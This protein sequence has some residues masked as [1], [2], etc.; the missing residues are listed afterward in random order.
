MKEK[1]QVLCIL[2]EHNTRITTKSCCNDYD[3]KSVNKTKCNCCNIGWTKECFLC[4]C[5]VIPLLCDKVKVLFLSCHKYLPQLCLKAN[6]KNIPVASSHT[7]KIKT[8]CQMKSK[9]SIS[10]YQFY[11]LLWEKK[12]HW[13][14]NSFPA[15]ILVTLAERTEGSA[16]RWSFVGNLAILF[17]GIIVCINKFSTQVLFSFWCH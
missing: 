12:W 15:A 2:E 5:S 14:K 9:G 7:T 16:R 17:F 11:Q 8:K 1:L 10:K 4:C 13:Q 3:L 6:K